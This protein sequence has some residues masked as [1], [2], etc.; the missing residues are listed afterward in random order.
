MF[1]KCEQQ[2]LTDYV[3]LQSMFFKHKNPLCKNAGAYKC[4][5]YKKVYGMWVCM[6]KTN[7]RD[8]GSSPVSEP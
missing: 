6:C 3:P 5:I 8:S 1:A 4:N 2:M 7:F